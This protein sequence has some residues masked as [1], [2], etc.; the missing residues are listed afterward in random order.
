MQRCIIL[1]KFADPHASNSLF[2]RLV[3]AAPDVEDVPGSF[4]SEEVE[5]GWNLDIFGAQMFGRLISFNI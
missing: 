4:V 2:H 5:D 1:E 3:Q